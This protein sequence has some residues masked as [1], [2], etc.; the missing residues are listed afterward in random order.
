MAV[1]N[2]YCSFNSYFSVNK[3]FISLSWVPQGDN[4]SLL[5]LHRLSLNVSP[6]VKVSV[7]WK[8]WSDEKHCPL[9]T[10][11]AVIPSFNQE[12]GKSQISVSAGEMAP[13]PSPHARGS[14]VWCQG[15]QI[16]NQKICPA[17]VGILLLS[18][19]FDQ[20]QI[21]RK[22]KFIFKSYNIS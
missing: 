20:G 7:W 5:T 15:L 8:G 3:R 1:L 16:L 2:D 22:F 14:C 9:L 17:E 18:R 12:S 11:P 19:L 6:E 4:C 13:A 10:P 21:K